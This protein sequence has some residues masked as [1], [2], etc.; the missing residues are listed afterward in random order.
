MI[1]VTQEKKENK[2]GT[3]YSPDL[4][5]NVGNLP[6]QERAHS[7]S[8]RGWGTLPSNVG[9]LPCSPHKL[10]LLSSNWNHLLEF[11]EPFCQRAPTKS[12][13]SVYLFILASGLNGETKS[14]SLLF[15]KINFTRNRQLDSY[16]LFW[17]RRQHKRD[18]L[19]NTEVVVV[20]TFHDLQTSRIFKATAR[21]RWGVTS[22]VAAKIY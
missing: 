4:R 2:D 1:Q 8:M 17:N 10:K 5:G 3:Q 21:N 20:T 18:D 11:E 6:L 13:S 19:I 9:F 7:G 16:S 22:C 14:N 12:C 15:T